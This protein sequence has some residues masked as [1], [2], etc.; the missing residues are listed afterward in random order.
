[1][2]RYILTFQDKLAGVRC[3]DLEHC[4]LSTEL[5]QVGGEL[6]NVVSV[7]GELVSVVSVGSELVSAVSVACR[8]TF[9]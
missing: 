6:V 8:V 2:T 3:S 7:G 9:S 4:W 5:L 1:M